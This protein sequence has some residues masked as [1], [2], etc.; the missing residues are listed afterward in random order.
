MKLSTGDIVNFHPIIGGAVGSTGHIIQE[1]QY[2]PNDFG[3]D[4]AWVSG[5]CG[6]VALAA[7]SS[8]GSGYNDHQYPDQTHT[9]RGGS[10]RSNAPLDASDFLRW[11]RIGLVKREIAING[12]YTAVHSVKEGLFLLKPAIFKQY[13]IEK[14]IDQDLHEQLSNEFRKLKIHTANADGNSSHTYWVET[15]FKGAKPLNG[16]VIPFTEIYG[17]APRPPLNPNLS[18][19]QGNGSSTVRLQTR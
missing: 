3:C 1:I 18:R 12:S 13:L 11:L 10:R 4:V 15:K 9:A 7:L 17:N 6:C 16:W 8:T 19:S 14:G 2:A 5:K